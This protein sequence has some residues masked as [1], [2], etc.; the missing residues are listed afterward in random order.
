[1]HFGFG[2][3]TSPTNKKSSRHQSSCRM[4]TGVLI[5]ALDEVLAC[6]TIHKLNLSYCTAY[7]VYGITRYIYYIKPLDIYN[8]NISKIGISLYLPRRPSKI[9]S[10][11]STRVEVQI[12]PFQ[13]WITRPQSTN[14]KYLNYT[15]NARYQHP[16]KTLDRG[17]GRFDWSD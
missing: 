11:A 16:I 13:I 10:N 4:K 3:Q 8:Q 5:H 6:A 14:P 9:S 2:M 15:N 17:I 1:M 7:T 12:S